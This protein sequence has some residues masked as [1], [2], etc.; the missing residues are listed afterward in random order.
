M[1]DIPSGHAAFPAFCLNFYKHLRLSKL[2]IKFSS[3]LR[4]AWKCVAR[5]ALRTQLLISTLNSTVFGSMLSV[6]LKTLITGRKGPV[7]RNREPVFTRL[8]TSN[9]SIIHPLQMYTLRN[10]H[11]VRSSAHLTSNLCVIMKLS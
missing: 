10:S 5:I 6:V 7:K 8:L 9:P 4:S 11:S 3:P 2:S 1:Y